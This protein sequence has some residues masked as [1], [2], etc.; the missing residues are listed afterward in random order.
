MC[1]SRR[2][3]G[4]RRHRREQRLDDQR[5]WPAAVAENLPTF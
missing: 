4:S 1:L 2:R 3:I 5:Q